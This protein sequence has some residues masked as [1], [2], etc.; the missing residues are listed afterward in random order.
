MPLL[1]MSP[2]PSSSLPLQLYHLA[3]PKGALLTLLL[4][5]VG[6]GFGHWDYALVLQASAL[7]ILALMGAWTC[8]HAGTMWLNA[9]L[10]RGEG[11]VLWGREAPIPERIGLYALLALLACVALAAIAHPLTG[12]CALA[13]ALLAVLYSHRKTA[14]KGHPIGG[15]LVNG[16]GYGLLSPLAGWF[17]VEV[18]LTARW[19]F[20]LLTIQLCVL[21]LYFGAQAFQQE[22]DRRHGHRTLVVTAGPRR[23]L[24]VARA[25]LLAGGLLFF[26]FTAWGWFPRLC[27]LAILVFSCLDRWMARWALEAQGG[28][29]SRADGMVLRA[30]VAVIM[31]T[32]LAL[33]QFAMDALNG[34]PAS[35][36]ATAR[37]R[38]AE[39]SSPETPQSQR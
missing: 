14:W 18:P 6:F 22:D 31:L 11:E 20:V 16:L 27:L 38:P 32:G 36:M 21:G 15:P 28:D 8:L 3:R 4:P 10:D 35:G 5:A 9:A 25:L 24:Q 1:L 13:A 34:D 30:L 19:A 37:G 17:L 12:L 33:G 29:R 7:Q 23:T 26:G 39:L 2:E